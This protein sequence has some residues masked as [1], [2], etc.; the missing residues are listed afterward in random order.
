MTEVMNVVLQFLCDMVMWSRETQITVMTYAD[1]FVGYLDVDGID[2]SKLLAT[3]CF[4]NYEIVTTFGPGYLRLIFED[5]AS[6]YDIT[7][8]GWLELCA[9]LVVCRGSPVVENN[10]MLC[11]Y[12]YSSSGR[13]LCMMQEFF[14]WDDRVCLLETPASQPVPLKLHQHLASIDLLTALSEGDNPGGKVYATSFLTVSDV[15]RNVVGCHI[16]INGETPRIDRDRLHRLHF[17]FLSFLRTVYLQSAVVD[18]QFAEEMSTEDSGVWAPLPRKSGTSLPAGTKSLMEHLLDQVKEYRDLVKLRIPSVDTVQPDLESGN[19]LKVLVFGAIVPLLGD[20]F[21]TGSIYSVVTHSRQMIEDMISVISEILTV[22]PPGMLFVECTGAY[23]D[24]NRTTKDSLEKMRAVLEPKVIGGARVGSKN[25]SYKSADVAAESTDTASAVFETGFKSMCDQL[26]GHLV[27][28]DARNELP[29]VL[30]RD[31]DVPLLDQVQQTPNKSGSENATEVSSTNDLDSTRLHSISGDNSVLKHSNLE[32]ENLEKENVRNVTYAE[33]ISAF[34][35]MFKFCANNEKL[36]VDI[37][38]VLRASAYCCRPSTS[39]PATPKESQELLDDMRNNRPLKMDHETHS[40]TLE[41][42][43]NRYD[44]V[45]CTVGCLRS[46]AMSEKEQVHIYSLGFLLTLLQGG[47]E[48]VQR[49]IVLKLSKPTE[50]TE[51]FWERICSILGDCTSSLKKYKRLLKTLVSVSI[52]DPGTENGEGDGDPTDLWRDYTSELDRAFGRNSR[53]VLSLRL[54]QLCCVGQCAGFQDMLVKQEKNTRSHNI[55]RMCISLF[56]VVQPLIELSISAGI[57]TMAAFGMQLLEVILDSIRGTH[58]GN[59]NEVLSSD[60]LTCINRIFSNSLYK[61][62]E[63]SDTPPTYFKDFELPVTPNDMRCWIRWS[64]VRVLLALFENISS[65]ELPLQIVGFFDVRYIIS[66]ILDCSVVMGLTVSGSD[67]DTKGVLKVCETYI[68]ALNRRETSF[69]L[70]TNTYKT[71]TRWASRHSK[72]KAYNFSA[73]AIDS[74]RSEAQ[75]LWQILRHFKNFDHSQQLSTILDDFETDNP[76]MCTFLNCTNMHVEIGKLGG[77]N[78]LDGGNSAQWVEMVYFPIG[79]NVDVVN[80]QTFQ[81]MF[82]SQI[83]HIPREDS[84]EKGQKFMDS[85]KR[86]L[87]HVA[88]FEYVSSWQ[89][90][91][92]L[93]KYSEWLERA[94]FLLAILITLLLIFFYGIPMDPNTGYIFHDG[95][96]A[97]Q[98]KR[99]GYDNNIPYPFAMNTS[100]PAGKG[101]TYSSVLL[102]QDDSV[103]YRLSLLTRWD[104]AAEWAFLPAI[105]EFILFLGGVHFVCSLGKSVS[106]LVLDFPLSLFDWLQELERED[107]EMRSSSVHSKS[108]ASSSGPFSSLKSLSSFSAKREW[109][110]S[111][112]SLLSFRK[113]LL[114]PFRHSFFLCFSILGLANSPFFYPL[115]LLEYF[116][117]PGGRNVVNALLI[118]GPNL[119]RTFLVGMIVLVVWGFLSYAFFSTTAIEVDDS[120]FSLYQCVTKHILDSFRGD[121]TTVLGT[122]TNWTFPALVFWE[123]SWEGWKTWYIMVFLVWWTFL[124]QPIIQ[125]QIMDAFSRIRTEETTTRTDLNQRCF[126]SGVSRFEFNNYPGEWEARAG[127]LYAWNFFLYIRHL[128]TIEAEDRNGIEA[129]VIDAYHSG[130]GAFLPQGV[131][132]AAQWETVRDP[133][134]DWRKSMSALMKSLRDEVRGIEK[135]VEQVIVDKIEVDRGSGATSIGHTKSSTVDQRG[136]SPLLGPG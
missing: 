65:I 17:S 25:S 129:S 24:S 132:A 94:S 42:V 22:S 120:C 53:S 127:G 83:E 126:I 10:L 86:M 134:A 128:E 54:L 23:F 108:R 64:C 72:V 12:L 92:Q 69:T 37:I 11:G 15:V 44:A 88:W 82:K 131:F 26:V 121:I 52:T 61:P 40:E 76:V 20:Y 38:D 19:L 55:L 32:K 13:N 45:G 36:L 81:D 18:A 71:L 111:I 101:K 29:L 30:G 70:N 113:V 1:V 133:A 130:S 6:K 116:A 118:G 56:G 98:V 115:C 60:L 84:K 57:G 9:R 14:E 4:D 2:V 34:V 46:L 59:R 122:F 33:I 79:K 73:A 35:P 107:T 21:S 96:F 125:G 62:E 123:D 99:P 103:E 102:T 7:P 74:I 27:E 95:K 41:W 106:F 93:L 58:Q 63:S 48:Q 90:S 87:R 5:F 89:V 91:R 117:M 97:P 80:S 47:N 119:A 135:K 16:Q 31:G 114:S 67:A 68:K 50:L 85:V 39:L 105:K 8:P 124:L 104:H 49:T 110:P 78:N 75:G 66:Q 77:P 100:D 28:K 43:Q 112:R 136:A 3:C 51:R 109:R